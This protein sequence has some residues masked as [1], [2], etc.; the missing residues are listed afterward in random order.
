MFSTFRVSNLK[1]S[2]FISR[3]MSLVAVLSLIF[4]KHLSFK[5]NILKMVD[6]SRKPVCQYFKI[7]NL[8]VMYG[9]RNALR[10]SELPVP[11]PRPVPEAFSA[12]PQSLYLK[13]YNNS[14]LLG[15]CGMSTG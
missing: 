5:C 11:G 13:T 10:F 15:P 2:R 8:F 3:N 6:I 7:N 9:L 12:H 14:D 1:L 4:N